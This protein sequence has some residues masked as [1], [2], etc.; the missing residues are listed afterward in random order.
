M[1]HQDTKPPREP[2]PMIAWCLG[3]LV[4]KAVEI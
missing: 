1:N 4:V 2:I 3:V